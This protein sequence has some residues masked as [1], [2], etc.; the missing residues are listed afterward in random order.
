MS[1]VDSCEQPSHA[2]DDELVEVLDGDAFPSMLLY[3]ISLL[4]IALPCFITHSLALL[5]IAL[6]CLIYI[7]LLHF[8]TRVK[9]HCI[10]LY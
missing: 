8:E 7:A 2:C 9:S 6:L 4:C 1:L 3:R 5:Y 10:E